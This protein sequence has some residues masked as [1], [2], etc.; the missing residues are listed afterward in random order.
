MGTAI[1]AS[2][3][4]VRPSDRGHDVIM[5]TLVP[6]FSLGGVRA[7]AMNESHVR[8]VGSAALVVYISSIR[9]RIGGREF[10][11]SPSAPMY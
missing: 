11:F 10:E 4:V 2:V 1:E 5:S 8:D 7:L 9:L 6:S 3:N